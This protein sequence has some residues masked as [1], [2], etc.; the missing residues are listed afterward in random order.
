MRRIVVSL[1][2]LGF[3]LFLPRAVMAQTGWTV[4]S[5]DNSIQVTISQNTSG[6][7]E[8]SVTKSGFSVIETSTLG[9]TASSST[10][11]F[12]QNLTVLNSSTATINDSYVLPIGK[13]ST[14][15]NNARELMLGVRNSVGSNASIIFRVYNDGVAYRYTI[16]TGISSVTAEESTFNLPG[17]AT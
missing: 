15:T 7:L 16:P 3:A 1:I 12:F 14:Y 6:G 4:S 13:R 9:I 2:L 8:F 5:P 10:Y 17:S 11:T